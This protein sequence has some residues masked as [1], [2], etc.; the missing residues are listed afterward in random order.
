[1]KPAFPIAL[2]ILL[3]ATA[4]LAQSA[5]ELKRELQ[6]REATAKKENDADKLCEVA[7]WASEKGLAAD[8][9]RIFTNVLKLNPEH[10]GA[11][12][13][14]GNAKW[15]GKWLPKKKVDELRKAAEMADY[16]AKGFVEVDG[17]WVP[18][19]EV[20]D[21]RQGIFHH[22][23]ELVTKAEKLALLE[24]KVR[25]PD[26][27]MLIPADKAELAAQHYYPIGREDRWGDEKAADKHHGDINRPWVVRTAKGTMVSTLPIATIRDYKANIDRGCERVA[28]LFGSKPLP[29]NHR[30]VVIVASTS[31]EY[32]QYGTGLG[33]ETS[34]GAAFI[35]RPE[36]VLKVGDQEA[37]RAAVCIAEQAAMAP[38]YIRHAAAMSYLQEKCALAEA[39][40]PLWFLH[41]IGNF[42]GFFENLSDGAHFCRTIVVKH[43][44]VKNLKG[45]MNGFAINAELDA[46]QILH[47]WTVAGL[48]IQFATQGGDKATTDAMVAVTKAF[49]D[50]NARQIT[51][52][53]EGLEKALIGAE[54]QVIAYY[55]KIRNENR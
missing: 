6:T 52:S 14:I 45:F 2:A 21:A 44:G 22:D 9:K 42:A 3:T 4:A 47:N 1:M 15:E 38:F 26:T 8:A 53:I 7:K 33:D 12:Q 32:M 30:P 10:E 36:A 35:M 43:G 17:A 41:G 29:P 25:H 55:D 24:G 34:S 40:V 28:P 27:G 54:E 48:L 5:R 18:P 50:G 13:G 49:E 39:T 16:K 19:D 46:N 20:E 31:D 37:T 51:K 11:N 23:G